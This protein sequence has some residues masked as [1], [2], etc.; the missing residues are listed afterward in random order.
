MIGLQMV[1]AARA[2]KMMKQAERIVA[3]LKCL[4]KIGGES[5]G[6]PDTSNEYFPRGL[7]LFVGIDTARRSH[8]V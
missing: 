7:A 4:F 6:V 3:A 5:W 8:A 1:D 2:S